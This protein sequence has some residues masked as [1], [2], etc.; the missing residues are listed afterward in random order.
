MENQNIKI[1]NVNQD[2]KYNPIKNTS[3]ILDTDLSEKNVQINK[4]ME[5]DFSDRN[6]V[7]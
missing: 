6:D 3:H 5:S 7:I 2:T 1:Q 4:T